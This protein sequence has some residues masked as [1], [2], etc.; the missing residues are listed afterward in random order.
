[1]KDESY[2]RLAV[3]LVFT[4]IK[5]MVQTQSVLLSP[6]HVV[7]VEMLFTYEEIIRE[8]SETQNFLTN[9]RINFD[10]LFNGG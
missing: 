9:P 10:V 4:T 1:M 2:L 6:T 8:E 5:L 7:S 3:F